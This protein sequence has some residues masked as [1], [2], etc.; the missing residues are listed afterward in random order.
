M[1]PYMQEHHGNPSSIH[2]YGRETRAAIDNSR[3]KIADHLRVSPGEIFFTSGGT[4]ANNMALQSGVSSL[5]VQH[6]ISS[7]LEHHAVFHT[8]EYLESQ[9]KCKLHWVNL[10]EEG[11]ID[12]EHFEELL[13]DNEEVMVSLMY[14]N[15]EIGNLLPMEKVGALCQKHGAIFHSDTVQAIGHYNLNFQELKLD[16]ASCTGHK[17]H[18]PKSTGFLYINILFWMVPHRQIL[19]PPIL[20]ELREYP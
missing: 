14:A 8:L 5:G 12:L 3:R 7:K 6:V 20:M 15:N 4:E 9:G 17:F 1:L 11:V 2:S 16:M 13:A 18:G 19:A 10:K